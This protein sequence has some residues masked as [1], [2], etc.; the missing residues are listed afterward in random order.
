MS[1]PARRVFFYVVSVLALGGCGSCVKDEEPPIPKPAEANGDAGAHV[2][3][4]KL[5]G[6]GDAFRRL[7]T[8]DGGVRD[9]H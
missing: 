5:M 1:A 4:I 6:K 7:A 8:R 2:G 9:A 3:A